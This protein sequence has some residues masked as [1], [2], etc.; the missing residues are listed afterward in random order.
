MS[1]KKHFPVEDFITE[2]EVAHQ[3][4]V[5]VGNVEWLVDD[6]VWVWAQSVVEGIVLKVGGVQV[7]TGVLVDSVLANQLSEVLHGEIAWVVP[8][9]GQE[10]GTNWSVGN[11]VVSLEHQRWS[12]VWLLF[13][14]NGSFNWG[15]GRSEMLIDQ[16]AELRGVDLTSTWDNDV[17]SNV[18]LVVELLDVISVNCV[19]VLS[20]TSAWLAQVMI[21]ESS[22]VDV[23]EGGFEG[24]HA[25]GVLVNGWFQGFDL[26]WLESGLE[27]DFWQE[28]DR[29]A[30]L[31]FIEEKSES[32]DFSVD[33]NFEDSSEPVDPFLDL[34]LWVGL[35]TSEGSMGN[36]LGDWAVFKCLL[37]ASDFNID[38]DG[39]LVAGPVFG[40]DSD[41]VAELG[42]GGG[43]GGLKSFRDLT[44]W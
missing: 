20:D 35:G 33:F 41:S 31:V 3:T 4:S 27:D 5:R 21:S 18:K 6:D 2:N 23:L 43:S 36:E 12:Q 19:S 44:P 22:V 37:S 26:D 11:F 7:G 25:G 16:L 34:L 15:S 32:A 10:G 1:H 8:A 40:G 14:S 30:H 24:V 42:D 28:A 9:W 17:L 39:S 29:F 13:V 38:S